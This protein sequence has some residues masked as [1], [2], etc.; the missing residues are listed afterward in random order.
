M[1]RRCQIL[2]LI[3]APLV[4]AEQS[5]TPSVRRL[6]HSQYNNTVRDLLGDQTHPADIFPQED[7]VNG[8]KNQI[9]AQD[10]SPLLAEAYQVAALK[11]A[12]AAIL[13]GSDLRHRLPCAPKSAGDSECGSRFI[14][15]FGLRAFRRPLD[16]AELHRYSGLL[17]KETRRTGQFMDGVQLVIEAMLQSPRFLFRLEGGSRAY[18]VASRLSYFL[19]DSMPD[20]ELFAAAA[21][22]ELATT[23]GVEKEIPRML[24]DPRARRR[25]TNS[26]VNGCASI[27]L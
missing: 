13:E 11:L 3:A 8:F 7:Y 19:W 9:A 16:D 14:R 4:A 10:I 24:A 17:V 21:S 5:S 27:S 23:A 6:T 18:D 26:Q 15:Q 12:K 25:S 2:F 20:E 22:G 1:L